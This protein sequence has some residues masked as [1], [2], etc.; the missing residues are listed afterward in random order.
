[1]A[2]GFQHTE[3]VIRF[4]SP[5]L[6]AEGSPLINSLYTL[7]ILSPRSNRPG[8][9]QFVPDRFFVNAT[10]G[11]PL[12]L[13]L[14]P[15]DRYFPLG[16]YQVN[17]YR[18]GNSEAIHHENWIVPERRGTVSFPWRVSSLS[19]P[20]PMPD[21]YFSSPAVDWNGSFEVINNQLNWLTNNPPVGT[22]LSVSYT[23]AV[24]L[25]QLIQIP[26]RNSGLARFQY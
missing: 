26:E 1:M 4:Q 21:D 23:A 8:L 15:S 13:K 2:A 3:I 7:E 16:R 20:I 11:E 5:A 25:D 10:I 6:D 19:E 24:T 18:S 12:Y 14:L 17:Y 9:D 22:D